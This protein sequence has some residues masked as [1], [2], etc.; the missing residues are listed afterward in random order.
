MSRPNPETRKNPL[1]VRRPRV[2]RG[3]TLV[4]LVL[5]LAATA[6]I[7]L[8]VATMLNAVA[9]GSQSGTD[10][11]DLVPRHRVLSA[12]L[13]DA[14]RHARQVVDQTDTTLVLWTDDANDNDDYDSDEIAWIEYDGAADEITFATATDTHTP[15]TITLGDLAT[16]KTALSGAGELDEQVWGR[17]VSAFTFSVDAAPIA[18]QLVTW[19]ATFTFG[20]VSDTQVHAEKVGGE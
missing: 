9:Y 6:F 18:T 12:R 13:A 16:T 4:E 1:G 15:A 11:R 10:T 20:T 2:R 8:A 14:V 3:L 19:H 7:G 5:A 17:D